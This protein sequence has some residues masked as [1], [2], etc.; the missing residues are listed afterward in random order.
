MNPAN[1]SF[2]APR[3]TPKAANAFGGIW[4]LTV[5]RFFSLSHWLALLGMFVVLALL[6]Y[7]AGPKSPDT[8]RYVSWAGGF[9]ACFLVPLL[10]FISA[11]G[12]MRDDLKPASIDYVFTRPVGRPA[13]VLFRYLAHVACIQI[14]FLLALAVVVAMGLSR[15][16]D[17]LWAA[18]PA[19][20]LT[21]SLLVLAFSAF[22][23]LCGMVTS[24]YII[25]GL[26]YGAVV[27]VGIGN[28]PTPL[29]QISMIRQAAGILR[30]V[31]D[32]AKN[33][34]A[35]ATLVGSLSVSGTC[36]LLLA[37]AALMLAATAAV[38]HFRELAGPSNRAN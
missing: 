25:L 13:F 20:F 15:G 22:G 1:P 37:M 36:A 6:S 32:D 14:E 24:R 31:I 38:F 3:V 2:P 4:R 17:E 9:Y 18:V 12:A 23:F 7:G 29:N 27:E 30:P 28:V 35:G 33:G 5:R 11:G 34:A 10:A 21:Q 16:L 26:A 8:E 19:L